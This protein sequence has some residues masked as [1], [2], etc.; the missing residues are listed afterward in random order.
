MKDADKPRFVTAMA[1]LAK[2]YPKGKDGQ[3][4]VVPWRLADLDVDAYFE[5]LR[6]E[7]IDRLERGVRWH[8]GHSE[9]FP[10]RP[11][12]LRKSIEAAPVP[13]P[14]YVT[15]DVTALPEQFE[16]G[17]QKLGEIF[18]SLNEK[19]GTRLRAE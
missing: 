11:A 7:S 6:D 2:Q 1:W 4:R 12:S 13:A 18:R 3:G 5:A 8:Y 15:A 19:F 9:F 10:D 16:M 14:R 17:K